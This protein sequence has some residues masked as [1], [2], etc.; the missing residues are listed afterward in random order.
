PVSGHLG[1]EKTYERVAREFY[2]LKML[3]SIKHYIRTCDSCQRN[4]P[5]NEK[6]AGLLQPI[7]LPSE[8]WESVSMDFIVQLPQTRG[9]R[10][11][12]I[13][14]YVDRLTK[15]SHFSPSYT[16]DDAPAVAR[17]FVREIFRH[18]GLPR[19]LVTDR[20]PKFTSRFWRA[21]A[22]ILDIRLAISS[23]Y[24]PQTDGQMERM[25]CTL[26]EMLRHYV[27][28]HQDNWDELLPLV[29]F[30]YN[31]ALNKSTN[32]TPFYA[33]VSQNVIGPLR[34]L[35]GQVTTNVSAVE[36]LVI[37]IKAIREEVL[38]TLEIAQKRQKEYADERRSEKEYVIGNHVLVDITHI[39]PDVY[40]N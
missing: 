30:A 15:R 38:E 3:R 14:V 37:R 35:K 26:E 2:W 27:A 19:S 21:L 6:P 7:E 40:K 18:H 25:N 12:A 29:E 33:D 11:D 32:H 39:K 5:S 4:K 16:S 22:K 17:N 23:S 9:K 20:D 13:T 10:Y 8:R 1:V 36:D 31:D 34:L 24:H 28:Y